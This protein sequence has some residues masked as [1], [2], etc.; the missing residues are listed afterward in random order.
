MV[1]R[2]GFGVRIDANNYFVAIPEW[3]GE[4]R[5]A[6]KARGVAGTTGYTPYNSTTMQW[7]RWR[8]DGINVYLE[9]APSANGP[10]TQLT[11]YPVTFSLAAMRAYFYAGTGVR[12][13]H[14][15]R[16]SST[17]SNAAIPRR[18]PQAPG[19]RRLDPLGL[20]ASDACREQ[21][22]AVAGLL[23]RTSISVSLGEVHTCR[24]RSRRRSQPAPRRGQSATAE[25]DFS[26]RPDGR[27][28]AE[29]IYAALGSLTTE[30]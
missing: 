6:N 4:H 5:L 11:S 25:I 3:L 10:W 21:H 27:P 20:C 15:A 16:R 9:A 22:L 28:L 29:E 1:D 8:S 2:D 14:P 12:R 19:S 23:W 7:L 13:H 26:I 17:T 24:E 30:G 18:S